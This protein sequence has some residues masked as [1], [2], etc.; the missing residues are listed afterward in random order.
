MYS[1]NFLVEA[2]VS[3]TGRLRINIGIHP[4]GFAWH[5]GPGQEFCTPQ[6]LVVR[7]N[8]GLGGLSRMQHRIILDKIL[9]KSWADTSPPILLNSWEARYFQVN[10]T[11]V[12]EM[13]K[14]AV[15][16]GVNL[17][18]LDDGWFGSRD[19][20]MSSL[21][22]WTP[23]KVKF[24]HGLKALADEINSHGVKFGL[25]VEPEMVS[26]QSALYSEH[27]DW[28]LSVP[29]RAKQ[30][31]RHQLVLDLSRSLVVNYLFGVLECL[32]SAANIEYVKWSLLKLSHFPALTS[33]I[34]SSLYN[35]GISIDL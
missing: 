20:I 18:V 7:S 3:E 19:D 4:M 28:C 22:D 32:F 13:V 10:H 35:V 27:P 6:V 31:G 2:E 8:K 33:L 5:L 21:G 26:E 11:N 14:H 23:N 1:G 12:V 16:I 9:P 29:G 34:Y 15:Q 30:L 25:W 24:P 17:L